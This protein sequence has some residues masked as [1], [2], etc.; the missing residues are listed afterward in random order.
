[1]NIRLRF[2]LQE[3]QPRCVG[4]QNWKGPYRYHLA[5]WRPRAGKWHGPNH[6]AN[7]ALGLDGGAPHS[8]FT[9]L[10]SPFSEGRRSCPFWWSSKEPCSWELAWLRLFSR[11]LAV[12]RLPRGA[13][14]ILLQPSH[15]LSCICRIAH[16]HHTGRRR[17]ES[18]SEGFATDSAEPS[19][20]SFGSRP[21]VT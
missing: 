6:E 12:K 14:V 7:E 8:C 21:R 18:R 15:K 16:E 1:M 20:C 4:C 13:K 19:L 11:R 17:A 10:S 2:V 9:G 3:T 5:W